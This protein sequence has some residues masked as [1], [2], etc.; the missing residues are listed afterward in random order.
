MLGSIGFSGI[1]L[2]AL[3]GLLLVIVLGMFVSSSD[4]L[5]EGIP[6]PEQPAFDIPAPLVPIYIRAQNERVSWARLA[7]I[8]KI[9]TNFGEEKARRSDTIGSLGLP[10]F[11]WNSYR[12]DG[13]EDNKED[14]DNPYDVI[15]TLANYFQHA[16]DDTDTAADEEKALAAILLNPEDVRLVHAKEAEYAAMLLINRDWLWPVIG[17]SSI[18]SPYGMR[19][20]PV[21]GESGA[22]HDGIDIPA[23]RGTPVVAIQDGTVIEVSFGSGG[24]G[25]LIRLQHAG[26]VQSFYGHL[27]AIGVR[28]GQ[29]VLRDEVIGAVG[30]TGKSTGPHLHLGMTDNGQSVNPQ[31]FW[32]NFIHG[33]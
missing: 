22:F 24:Y 28:P 13:D 33:G 26:G 10:F 16:V 29:R 21:T 3:F 17:Y 7:A 20:D 4:A 9:S 6:V 18:S 23:P 2:L 8:Q 19:T 11:I 12:I 25:N 5:L 15:F 14:W 27:A 1:S 30:S 31:T 32:P